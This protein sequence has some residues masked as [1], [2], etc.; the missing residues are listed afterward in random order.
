MLMVGALAVGLVFL[1]LV[2]HFR[3]WTPA[4]L[5][6]L[7]A[8]LSVGG[9]LVLLLVTGTD[10]NISSSMGLILLVGLVVKNGI[11]LLD[12]SEKLHA[13][14]Q[15]FETAIA[16]AGRIR[17]RP[18][19]MTTFALVAGMLPVALGRGEGAQFRAPLGV[20]VIGGVI[21]STLL[22]LVAIPTFYEILQEL[23]AGTARLLGIKMKPMHTGEM[24]IVPEAGD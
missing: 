1:I 18:I 10:L 8:P 13:E 11:M 21:T 20:A 15:P 24:E 9:A 2:V 17:L 6:L 23:K 7:A 12:F 22:T 5:I 16:E 3:A 19:L 14:G 4:L